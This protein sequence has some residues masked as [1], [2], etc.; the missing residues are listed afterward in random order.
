MLTVEHQK[1]QPREIVKWS[2]RA[3]LS[4]AFLAAGFMVAAGRIDYWQGWLYIGLTA[5]VEAASFFVLR[6]RADL[7]RERVKPGKGMPW[8]DLVYFI[9]STVTFL[10]SL[11]VA[12]LDAGRFGW[13]AVVPWWAV[14][15]GAAVYLFGQTIFLRAKYENR[16]LSSVVRLQKDRGQTVCSTGPYRFVR[17]PAYVGGILFSLASPIVLSSLWA[18]IPQVIACTALVVRTYLEDRLLQKELD[19]FADYAKRVRYRLLPGV[20]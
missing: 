4:L 5:A 10:A 20:W 19:G 18:L 15:G 1:A 12:A 6:H 16:F 8:W 13:G 3:F 17:H 2:V 7:M 14:A 9:V 11:A